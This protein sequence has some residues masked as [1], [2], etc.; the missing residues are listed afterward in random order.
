[1]TSPHLP[2]AQP[3]PTVSWRERWL[4]WRDR[5]LAD[6]GFRRR[7]I[8]FAPTR[9]LANGHARALFD[10]MAGFTYTQV[11]LACVRLD[12]FARLA[13][14]P[15]DL[16]ALGRAV[17]LPA[18]AL[19]RL[20]DAA[21]ALRLLQWRGPRRVGLGALG[22]TLVGNEAL[23]A[24]VEHHATLYADLADPVALLRGESRAG[25]AEI[26][27]YAVSDDPGELGPAQVGPYSALM[28]ASQVLVGDEIL[29]AYP[30][31]RHRCVLDVGGGEGTFLLRVAQAVPSAQLC[32][33]DLPAVADRARARFVAAGLGDRAQAVGGNFRLDP[34][35]VGADLATLLRVAHD[36]DDAT[37]HA[38]L[39][40]IR[41]CLAPGGHLLLAEPMAGAAGAEP[42]GA[43]YFGM[44]LL[45]M[46]SG[47]AR[48]A[49]QLMAMVRA[50]GFDRVELLPS[51]IPLQVGLIHASVN[52][53]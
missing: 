40:S 33:F 5:M 21:V 6:A 30:F 53:N 23:L 41:A 29:R 25:L 20:A 1:M 8:A 22:A 31:A 46:G 14:G 38:V 27:P 12:L 49:D 26:F 9:R 52:E 32:L 24:M 19:D 36:H 47:K 34:L 50:A 42:M 2:S 10:L 15:L 37:V 28:S 16:D 45:A 17:R 13:D 44:Y 18:D 48:T 7:A 43:A 4:T 51:R 35:P 11:L 3:W 39:R